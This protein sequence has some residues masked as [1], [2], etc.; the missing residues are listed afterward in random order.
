[1]NSQLPYNDFGTWLRTL[2]PYKIQKLSVNAG[3]S[4]PNRDGRISTG[5]CTFCDNNT[6]NPS[7]CDKNKTIRKQL[8]TG[9]LFFARKYPDMRYLAYFQ[10]YSNTYASLDT[11]K[12]LYEEAL[13]T[14]GVVGLVIGTRPDCVTSEI[15]DYI[16]NLSRQT[17]IIIE[18][19]IESNNNVTLNKINR[20]HS[21]ECS[22]RAIKETKERGILT[23]GHVILGLPDETDN[24]MLNQAADISTT[25]LDI[26][27]IHQLQIIKGTALAN[28]YNKHPFR[29]FTPESYIPLLSK[30]IQRLR[31][32]L[33]LDR[34]TSQ[35]PKEMLIA[36][37]WGLKNHEFTNMLVNYMNKND[38]HQ[39]QAY[40]TICTKHE[41][42]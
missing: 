39:G 18:Y 9:K 34:F 12:R 26:L 14:D 5:G 6:F 21:F 25:Q 8:E 42:K 4:C 1:M 17:F 19:G 35:A 23:G 7:Y 22:C 40:D 20:G 13:Q 31:P 29:L 11:L 2:F 33:I 16:G 10:A 30:Y 32:N 37:N 36:P 27:K 24:D 28:E 15:L 3:F 38:I 41:C